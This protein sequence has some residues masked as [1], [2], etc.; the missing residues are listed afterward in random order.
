MPRA[1]SVTL[2]EMRDRWNR[3]AELSRRGVSAALIAEQLGIT[4]RSV[5]RIKARQ[6]G[7]ETSRRFTAEEI[8]RVEDML[9]DGCSLSEIARTIGRSPGSVRKRWRG[10]GWTKSAGG[11]LGALRYK[12]LQQLPGV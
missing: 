12:A 4:H 7:V 3:V 11:E 8:A 2:E 10:Q 9:S 6:T 5:N 1:S